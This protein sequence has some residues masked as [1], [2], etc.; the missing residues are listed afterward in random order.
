MP[1]SFVTFKNEDRMKGIVTF[2]K[3]N[4]KSTITKCNLPIIYSGDAD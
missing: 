2:K 1:E 3:A 4:I